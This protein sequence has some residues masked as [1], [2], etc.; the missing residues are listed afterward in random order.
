MPRWPA[1]SAVQ[2]SS[3]FGNDASGSR[4]VGQLCPDE[5]RFK[6]HT[7]VSSVETFFGTYCLAGMNQISSNII[8][9]SRMYVSCVF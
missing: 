3:E 4:D 6:R 5:E 7:Y 9:N 2:L 1:F 8:R